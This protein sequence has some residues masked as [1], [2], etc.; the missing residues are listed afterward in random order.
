MD[1]TQEQGPPDPFHALDLAAKETTTA[2]A[3]A[4]IRHGFIGEYATSLTGGARMAKDIHV[5]IDADPNDARDL[6]LRAC[7]GFSLTM[8]NKLIFTTETQKIAVEFL[9]SV[10]IVTPSVF[11]RTMIKR[12]SL[13]SESA[14]PWRIEQ[15]TTDMENIEENIEELLNW[16]ARNGVK[17]N[18]EGYP[19]EAENYHLSAVRKLYQTKA[20]SALYSGL[21]WK[22]NIYVSPTTS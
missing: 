11:I 8:A 2:L 20:L 3:C 10:P 18:F 17:I 15:A 12:W 5:I 16:L 6:L 1:Q 7:S 9:R 19:K 4:N 14:R 21:H 13:I 22:R